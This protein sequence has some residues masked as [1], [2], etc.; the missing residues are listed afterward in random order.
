[1]KPLTN[2]ERAQLYNN[3][4]FRYQKI[5]EEIR[6]IQA[7]NFEVSDKDQKVIDFKKIQMNNIYNQTKKL[8]S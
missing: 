4:L 1:M 7:K 6:E 5:Q 3:M 2:Q 8:F